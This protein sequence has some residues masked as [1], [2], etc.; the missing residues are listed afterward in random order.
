MGTFKIK[1]D[2]WL[3]ARFVQINENSFKLYWS[4]LGFLSSNHPFFRQ[5]NYARKTLKTAVFGP[6]KTSTFVRPLTATGELALL[7]ECRTRDRKFSSS[8]PSGSGGRIFFSRVLLCKM[9]LM[10]CSFEPR[11]T[12]VAHKRPRSF[13]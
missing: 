10:R 6:T 7:V 5:T 8:N 13:C 9:T 2:G 3:Y 11:V 1:C 4:L 12:A